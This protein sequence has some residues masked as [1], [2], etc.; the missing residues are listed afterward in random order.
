MIL[1]ATIASSSAVA[2]EVSANNECVVRSA[3][4]DDL[5]TGLKMRVSQMISDTY[6]KKA[7]IVR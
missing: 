3:F 7:R 1:V 6:M 2:N 4:T 5:H